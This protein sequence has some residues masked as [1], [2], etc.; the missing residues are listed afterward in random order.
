ML[1]TDPNL[2][3]YQRPERA[4]IQKELDLMDDLIAGTPRMHAK[5]ST[6][7]YKWVDEKPKVYAIRSKIENC[8][9]GLGRTLSA[10]TGML[11]AQPPAMTWNASEA[12]MSPDWDDIDGNGTAGPV[13]MKRFGEK[14]L[15]DGL[16]VNLVD[17]TPP[18]EGVE[19]VTTKVAE[20]FNLRPTWAMYER[21]QVLSWREGKINNKKTLTRIV[22]HE[23]GMA[24]EGE[25][26]VKLVH[27][28]R[29]LSLVLTPDGWQAIWSL[30]ELRG[31][32]TRIEDYAPIAMGV[33]KNYKGE[34]ASFLPVSVAYAGRTD[35][36]LTASMPLLG[37]AYANLAHYQQSTDLRF[38]RALCAFPQRKIK[39]ELAKIKGPNGD[40]VAVKIPSGPMAV[41]HLAKDAEASWDELEGKS[42]DQLEK[43][44][45]EK[46]S[47]IGQMGLAF[48]VPQTRMAETA[49]AKRID[50]VAQNA[51]LSTA[52]Q[53]IEDAGNLSL[54]HH[55]WFRGIEK[56]DAPR[57]A[58]TKEFEKPVM[59][60]QTMTAWA[61]V[62]EKTG[63]PIE[64]I[65][66]EFKVKGLLPADADEEEI[67]A[68]MMVN[69]EARR[70]QKELEAE[71]AKLAAG[72][73][74]PDPAKPADP[75]K[76]EPIAA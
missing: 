16:C 8:F 52:G 75:P 35:A 70:K 31:E 27:R 24:D 10:A 58:L 11:Y 19:V 18:P 66:H 62:H 15:R 54:E 43:G 59:D 33:F 63:W 22:F 4:A 21:R 34:V 39:G 3:S 30:H 23:C 56:K 17:H 2:P 1:T 14:A 73:G 55:A 13:Y 40:M 72:G 37:V 45:T 42:M 6:Y 41:L 60:A 74:D 20:T 25:Y 36:T 71:Q 69:L 68:R 49:E 48:L 51:T 29:K 28:F 38:Y 65:V 76:K 47:Q 50:S 9:E 26:G 64:E 12:A 53:A 61:T 7:I 44:I 5:A 46:L 67:V 32:G 57:M